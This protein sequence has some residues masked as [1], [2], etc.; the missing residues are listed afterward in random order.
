MPRVAAALL[1]LCGALLVGPYL[2][3]AIGL[4]MGG[5]PQES[6]AVEE[7]SSA[8][9]DG[10]PR[11]PAQQHAV[12]GAKIGSAGQAQGMELSAEMQ[13]RLD[14]ADPVKALSALITVRAMVL[15]TGNA[16]LLSHVNVSESEAMKADQELLAGLNERGHVFNG[17]SIRLHEA[18]L[19][20]SPT[21]P[22]DATAVSATVIM[23]GY[24]EMD[25]AGA[26]VRQM[27]DSTPQELV[28]VLV[29]QEKAWKIA[30]VHNQG[31]V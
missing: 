18:A 19:T 30:G 5:T 15:T 7:V 22:E 4:T 28:F 31:G 12:T 9:E 23:S 29:K 14:D 6:I 13:E 24:T 3:N 8:P 27:T 20:D 1:V 10:N 25:S 21:V 16:G 17:L 26:A 11:E 2:L